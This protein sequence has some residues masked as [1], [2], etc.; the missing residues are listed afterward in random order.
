MSRIATVFLATSLQG[1]SVVR[2]LLKDGTFTVRAVT[3]DVSSDSARALSGLGC[4]VV[5]A[6]M[7]DKDAV[8][9][10]V[11]GAECVALITL[12][13]WKGIPE[14]TQGINVIDASKAAGV[15]FISF[16]TLPSLRDMSNGKYT[17]A[18]HFDDK[19]A[20]QK[21]LEA[22]QIPYACISP[23]NFLENV[24]PGRQPTF[25]FVKTETGYLMNTPG[26]AGTWGPAVTALL[27]QYT[28]RL[29]EI[30]KQT[31]VLGSARTTAEE[32][33]AELAKGLGKPVEVKH[34]GKA[35][36]PPIAD[37][38]DCSA[39][40]D[41]FPNVKIPDPRLKALGVEVGT[42]EEFAATVLKPSI[43]A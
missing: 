25:P 12:P 17:N 27:T 39:E 35:G 13:S 26:L 36:F 30:N 32:S 15:K 23:G 42:I 31:F 16:S 6:T 34:L 41:W 38:F 37:M 2:A 19:A 20:I 40:H 29:A 10:A 24:M 14:L 7:D 9:K 33:A 18:N 3:R 43:E 11:A 28:T 1:S 22:S 21:H 4:Q 8:S 5:G